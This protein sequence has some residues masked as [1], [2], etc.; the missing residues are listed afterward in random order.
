MG[1]VNVLMVSSFSAVAMANR[2][3]TARHG[4]FGRTLPEFTWEAT[5]KAEKL[6][7]AVSAVMV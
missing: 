7:R 4:H 2:R 6:R 5:D 1:F 3:E